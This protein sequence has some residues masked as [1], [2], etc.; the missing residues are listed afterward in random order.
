MTT[1]L[2]GIRFWGRKT[3]PGDVIRCPSS[4][5][6]AREQCETVGCEVQSHWHTIGAVRVASLGAGGI[7]EVESFRTTSQALR[8]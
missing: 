8:S 7:G 3:S 1:L 2:N 6:R 5:P 4:L